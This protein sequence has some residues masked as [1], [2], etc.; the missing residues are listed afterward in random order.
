MSRHQTDQTITYLQSH[1]NFLGVNFH[2]HGEEFNDS[3]RDGDPMPMVEVESLLMVYPFKKTETVGIAKRKVT[4]T[5]WAVDKL[6]DDSDP[7]VGMYGCEPVEYKECRS[8]AQVAIEVAKVV[9]EDRIQQSLAAEV[10]SVT[11]P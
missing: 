8:L 7:S 9:V 11:Y 4:R 1:L 2:V 10:E 3:L 5:M 6:V